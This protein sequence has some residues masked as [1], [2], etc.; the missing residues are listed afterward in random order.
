MSK[1]WTN[2]DFKQKP[3]ESI[4]FN[5]N[6]SSFTISGFSSGA[7]LSS[8]LMAMYNEHID[9]AGILAGGGPCAEPTKDPN[10]EFCNKLT[11]DD[12]GY[13]TDGYKGTP[14]YHYQGYEDSTVP[15]QL[16][17]DNADWS[18]SHDADVK[19]DYIDGFE[20]TF[21]ISNSVILDA[22][23]GMAP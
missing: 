17:K 2:I 15:F 1:E 14:M 3:Y 10:S 11:P 5:L 23:K 19:T 18:I 4:E 12:K 13:P 22:N 20:H 9:G 16:G 7:Y 21:P 6:A 8:N